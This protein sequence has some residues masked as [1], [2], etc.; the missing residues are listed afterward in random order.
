LIGIVFF[1]KVERS[2]IEAEALINA[3]GERPSFRSSS[4]AL[5]VLMPMRA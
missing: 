2:G 3:R 1:Q 5:Y 4:A